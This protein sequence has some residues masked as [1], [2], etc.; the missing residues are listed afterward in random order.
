MRC[1]IVI[2]FGCGFCREIK[3]I[4]VGEKQLVGNN[5]SLLKMKPI[6]QILREKAAAELKKKN[7]VNIVSSTKNS[8]SS[9]EE[10][11]RSLEKEVG[12]SD[13]DSSDN[14]TSDSNDEDGSV[15]EEEDDEDGLI[16]EKDKYGNIIRMISKL[17][18]EAKIAPLPKSLLPLAQCHFANKASAP[19]S[20][21]GD[22][23]K[24]RICFADEQQP[25][26]KKPTGPNH[27][28]MKTIQQLLENYEAPKEKIPFYCKICKFTG[29]DMEDFNVHRDSEFH[30]L[31]CVVERRVSYCKICR[32]Q[33]TSPDQLHE[34]NKGK[35]H[36]ERL[37]MIR[38]AHSS[39]S[40]S[41]R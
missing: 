39:N 30:R 22:T 12:S 15:Q 23:K 38:E 17:E 11:I 8:I 24:R 32:K 1:C 10:Q 19:S 25:A 40:S 14:D 33:F 28:S 4:F 5:F 13:D 9:L 3:R 21:Y 6:A 37:D 41:Y 2:I 34:H 27:V 18:K 26:S 7:E 36:L 16:Y 31:A 20:S 35:A 29:K